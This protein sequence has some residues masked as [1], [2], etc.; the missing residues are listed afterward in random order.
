MACAQRYHARDRAAVGG[1]GGG[2]GAT[3]AWGG[4]DT[5]TTWR[6]ATMPMAKTTGINNHHA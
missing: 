6:T 5:R 3:T 1:G 4:G 2:S